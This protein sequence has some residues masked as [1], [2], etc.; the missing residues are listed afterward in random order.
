MAG[1]DTA[2][3]LVRAIGSK[4]DLR[5][6]ARLKATNFAAAAKA[7]GVR[8]IVYLCELTRDEAALP[9][10]LRGRLDVG[11]ILG[12]SGAEVIEFRAPT[13]IGSGSLS[14]ELAK[15]LAESLPVL[16]LPSWARTP[17]QPIAI[18]DVLAYL[19]AAL[20]LPGGGS[21]VFEVGGPD[22][23]TYEAVVREYARQRG[24]RRSVAP[25]PLTTPRLSSLCLAM[26]APV[27]PTAARAFVDGLCRSTIV[28][29]S[30][31]AAEFAIR[32]RPLPEAI[33]RAIGCEGCRSPETRWSDALSASG[34]DEPCCSFRRG[35][36]FVDM[37]EIRVPVPPT[38]AFAPVQRIGGGADG[39]HS[40][41]ALWRIRGF[42]DILL[43]GVGLGRGRRDPE[44]VRPG[45]PIDCWRVQAYEQ[46]R[47]L[48][49]CAEMKLPGRGWLQFEVI[50]DSQGST[51]RQTVAFDPVGAGGLVYWYMFHPAHQVIFASMLRGLAKA[52]RGCDA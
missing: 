8:R 18:E 7:A 40:P 15:A 24:L 32:P 21:R 20:D 48:R 27:N 17:T 33:D 51:I 14:F 6:R 43:G 1:C 12:D 2:Y 28:R 5:A 30:A 38:Q 9:P 16:I 37:R 22:V 52:A 13:I 50:G 10:Y 23:T 26:M 34:R 3:Y 45:D 47:L 44:T 49:L 39:W 31:A 4:G 35:S 42:A 46:D 36:R 11:H 41:A 29:N 19:V 25:V